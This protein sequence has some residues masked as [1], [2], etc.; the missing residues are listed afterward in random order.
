M[1]KQIKISDIITDLDNGVTRA[2]IAAK[3]DITDREVKALFTHPKLK[4]KKAKKAFVPSFEI[5][6]DLDNT[7]AEVDSPQMDVFEDASSETIT[8][9]NFE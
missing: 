3:Y 2:Q 4:G 9:N 6:D 5:V 1:S 7:E 8:D